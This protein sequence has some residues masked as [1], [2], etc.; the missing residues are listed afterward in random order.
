MIAL[1]VDLETEDQE[2][3]EGEEAHDDP[4]IEDVQSVSQD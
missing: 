3:R 2:G 4:E 1:D